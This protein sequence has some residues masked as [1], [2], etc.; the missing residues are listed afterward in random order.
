MGCGAVSGT[1]DTNP[2]SDLVVHPTS[3]KRPAPL[4]RLPAIVNYPLVY[5]G[6]PFR[7]VN[8]TR[9]SEVKEI[10]ENKNVPDDGKN[11]SIAVECASMM[12]LTLISVFQNL[13]L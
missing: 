5:P 11:V 6:G 10:I 7:I 12:K 3:S 9:M 1:R 4:P 2:T 8:I 13:I